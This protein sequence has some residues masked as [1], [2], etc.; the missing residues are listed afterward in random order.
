MMWDLAAVAAAESSAADD[1]HHEAGGGGSGGAG[2]LGPGHALATKPKLVGT[3]PSSVAVG[4]AKAKSKPK[5]GGSAEGAAAV[6][7]LTDIA[8]AMLRLPRASAVNCVSFSEVG[9]VGPSVGLSVVGLSV[10]RLVG[11]G[12]S[13]EMDRGHGARGGE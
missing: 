12:R 10:G 5:G 6:V 3:A 7:E 13:R 4:G 8:D 11:R 9:P 2:V 1:E